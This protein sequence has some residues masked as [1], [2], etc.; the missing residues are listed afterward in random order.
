MNIRQDMDNN[1]PSARVFL[2][3]RERERQ[4]HQNTIQLHY[5]PPV[6]C[7]YLEVYRWP[8]PSF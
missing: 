5:E 3:A 4:E 1:N 2:N 8:K 6:V 7:C